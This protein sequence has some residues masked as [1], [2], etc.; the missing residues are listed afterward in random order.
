[1]S[2]K[3][4]DA[5]EAV[6]QMLAR[7]DEGADYFSL[8]GLP[9]SAADSDVQT[10][11]VQLARLVHPDLPSLRG[12]LRA[13]ATRAFQALTR[14]RLVLSDPG[15]RAEYE[16]SL[17]P[18]PLLPIDEK[19]NPELARIHMH[20]ARQLVARRD[21]EQAE[22]ALRIADRLYGD[23]FDPD[24]RAELGW[25][26]FNNERRPEHER[27]AESK[28]LLESV[29]AT[30]SAPGAVAQAHYY[31]AVWHRITGDVPK[32]KLHLEKC[33]AINAKHVDALREQRLL[34]RRRSTS[35]SVA[36]RDAT[37]PVAGS[38]SRSS[39][40]LRRPSSVAVPS[41]SQTGEVKKVPLEKKP[42]LLERL[43]GGKR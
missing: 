23:S 13:D 35:A 42:T 1:M 33:L 30:R 10:A 20:R 16:A 36:P 34:E 18:E 32:I 26:I 6:Q 43:F 24:C 11:F 12:E 40:A 3:P 17:E 28:A 9:R 14:A 37:A 21:W 5:A 27:V 31:L 15:R 22:A 39:S 19:P 2:S 25:A 4:P 29:L 41:A 38:T 8:L 7:I